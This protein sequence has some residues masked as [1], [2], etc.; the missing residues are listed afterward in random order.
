MVCSPQPVAT[1]TTTRASRPRRVRMQIPLIEDQC[2]LM[3]HYAAIRGL[4][5]CQRDLVPDPRWRRALRRCD[6]PGRGRRARGAG[7]G[8]RRGQDHVVP[9]DHRRCAGRSGE[10]ARRRAAP[11]DAPAR[12]MARRGAD[13]AGPAPAPL[14]TFAADLRPRP[15]LPRRRR[16]SRNRAS[17]PASPS[18]A[19]TRPGVTPAAGMPR[20]S[21]TPAPR[22]RCANR[23]PT[24]AAGGCPRSPAVSR[25]GSRSRCCSGR[26]PTCCSSTSRTTI[27]TSRARSGWR[28]SCGPAPKTILLISHDRALLAAVGDKIVTLEG[29]D[30]VDPRRVVRH[31]ACGAR[32]PHR[33]DRRGPPPLGRGAQATRGVAAR[34]PAPRVDGQRRVRVTRALD[35]DEDRT[36]RGDRADRSGARRVRVD[37]AGGQ[38]HRHAGGHL[39]GAR[40]ARAHRP[41]RLRGAVRRAGRRARP[42]RHR[43]EPLPAAAGRRASRP[44]RRGPPRRARRA[45]LLLPDPR[46]ARSCAASRC[47]TS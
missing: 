20:C 47:S 25:S 3:P 30:G 1:M 11:G 42:E 46:P 41:V 4:H 27:S 8:E 43:Q 36:V 28:T 35:E 44:R 17:G 22:S 13:G 39:R 19:P 7:R 29:E 10:R 38:P 24:R 16:A 6:L 32:R 31:V 26:T 12:R 5:R 14:A 9:C 15:W 23:S 2:V 40:A 34:V 45:R 21:G 18:R 33:P 37:E